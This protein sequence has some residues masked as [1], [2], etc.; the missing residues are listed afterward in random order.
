V[1]PLR[2]G[3]LCLTTVVEVARVLTLANA[4]EVLPRFFGLSKREAQEVAAELQPRE[5]PP[6]REVVTVARTPAAAPALLACA[7]T[8]S[9]FG[10]EVGQPTCLPA[11]EQR[12][13]TPAAAALA[14]SAP[15]SVEPLTGELSRIHVTLSRRVLKKA[16]LA[17]AALSHSHPGAGLAEIIEAGIDLL[18][19]R[20]ARRNGLVKK[21][22]NEPRP[23]ADPERIPAHVRRAVWK[24][25]GGR[26]QFPVASGG[27]CGS[28]ARAE[29]HHRESRHRGG[30]PTAEN[31]TTLCG[32]HHG[33][34]TRREFG[35]EYVD[36]IV[37]ERQA[38]AGR[39][40]SPTRGES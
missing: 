38:R 12:A 4:R 28:T 39:A 13:E 32:F 36:R 40:R 29:L 19:E 9:D 30:P 17:R 10:Q 5:V 21:P 26:C 16:E 25:D 14:R 3:K 34:E 35:D 6:L 11:D 1:A 7:P 37:R 22:R 27:V 2:E 18:L 20:H 15:E 24:R 8:A 23:S 31:L 33:V